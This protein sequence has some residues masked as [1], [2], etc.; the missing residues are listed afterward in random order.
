M[1]YTEIQ[2]RIDWLIDNDYSTQSEKEIYDL[3]QLWKIK[4]ERGDTE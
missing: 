1:K 4:K 2:E 3:K